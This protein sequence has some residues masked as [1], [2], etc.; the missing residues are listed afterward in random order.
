MKERQSLMVILFN[1]V[2]V[3]F[4]PTHVSLRYEGPGIVVLDVYLTEAHSLIEFSQFKSTKIV[5]MFYI[6]KFA[7]VLRQLGGITTLMK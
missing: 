2:P 4:L 6:D 1:L 7:L 5:I 3:Y